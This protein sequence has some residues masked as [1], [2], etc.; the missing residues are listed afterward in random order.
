MEF[1]DLLFVI[2][3]STAAF[4][5]LFILTKFMGNRQMSQLTTLDY[6]IG[7]S[8]GSIA[9]EMAVHPETDSWLGIPAMGVFALLAVVMNV[10]DDKSIRLRGKILG[11]PTVLYERGTLYYN[12]L[13]KSK[14]DLSELLTEC[15]GAG[16]F[17]LSQLELIIMEVNGK[18]SFLPIEAQR[19]LTPGDMNLAPKQSRPA[20]PV[21]MDGAVLTAQL[22]T[23]GNDENWLKK[24]IEIQGFSD[25]KDILLAM[26][27]D[28]NMLTIY[29][30]NEDKEARSYY[31]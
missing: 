27:D 31:R 17:D 29:E 28:G 2:L 30:K 24:Q 10:I 5:V 13:K 25:C 1:S 18:L 6:I 14:L 12:N 9:A 7:I 23:S 3:Q 20:I 21:I 16:Y 19:P 11:T 26:V 4:F 15:R 8:I 22:K